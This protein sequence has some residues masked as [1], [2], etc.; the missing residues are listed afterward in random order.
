MVKGPREATACPSTAR[1]SSSRVRSDPNPARASTGARAEKL[2]ASTEFVWPSRT[3]LAPKRW[4]SL[5]LAVLRTRSRVLS[6]SD[7][8]RTRDLRC[9]RPVLPFGLTGDQR[10]FVVR[11]GPSAHRFAGITGPG[12]E[13][14]T[15]SCGMCAGWTRYLSRNCGMSVLPARSE[16]K[17]PDSE[18]TRVT[19]LVMDASDWTVRIH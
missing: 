14:P 7:G 19:V 13:L 9:D 3:H 11:A 12:Q 17:R 8:T 15:T 1:I 10:G 18:L 2:D 6:G 16:C 4:N 5:E